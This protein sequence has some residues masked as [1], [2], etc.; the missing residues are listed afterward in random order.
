MSL[1]SIVENKKILVEKIKELE[2]L[3]F[4]STSQL[5]SHVINE[6][7]KT[8][9]KAVRNVFQKDTI[10]K[11]HFSESIKPNELLDSFY[12]HL[13]SHKFIAL[14]DEIYEVIDAMDTFLDAEKDSEKYFNASLLIVEELIDTFHFILEY[15]AELEEHYQ[16]TLCAKENINYNSMLY[17]FTGENNF[18][19][20]V[21]KM[22]ESEGS[23]IFSY[24]IDNKY[25]DIVKINKYTHVANPYTMLK[26]NREFV[27]KTNFKDWKNYKENFY[28]AYV[29]GELF[30]LNRQLYACF[31]QL[32]QDKTWLSSV[33]K[34]IKTEDKNI[35]LNLDS[36]KDIFKIIYGIYMSKMAENLRRQKEDPRY[37]G[38]NEGNIIGINV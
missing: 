1:L 38:K 35:E 28:D 36:T 4:E 22:L 20:N 2:E 37:T 10:K 17:Y 14:T 11:R 19:N 25:L 15:T 30:E 29:F 7:L 9:Y 23:H 12:Q 16:I 8:Q 26:I 5:A 24:L 6:C 27:R 21:F 31:F 18:S 34:L 3:N 33:Y 32:L 13:Y